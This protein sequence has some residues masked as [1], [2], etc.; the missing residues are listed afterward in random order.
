[1]TREWR[2]GDGMEVNWR[3]MTIAAPKINTTVSTRPTMPENN[4]VYPANSR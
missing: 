2:T 3:V 1:M 4:G